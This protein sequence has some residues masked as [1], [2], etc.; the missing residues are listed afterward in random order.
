MGNDVIHDRRCRKSPPLARTRHKGDTRRGSA[1]LQLATGR[2]SLDAQPI[3]AFDLSLFA[4]ERGVFRSAD[5]QNP[6]A[7]GIP[8]IRKD[9][10]AQKDSRGLSLCQTNHNRRVLDGY[11]LLAPA[12]QPAVL[13]HV[14]RALLLLAIIFLPVRGHA[15]L[16]CRLALTARS[17]S[18]T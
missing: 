12:R 9:V 15:R 10:Q 8:E 4:P 3:H 16:P 6:P 2:H 7:S 5:E 13:D 14:T 17:T 18:S 1:S 11:L